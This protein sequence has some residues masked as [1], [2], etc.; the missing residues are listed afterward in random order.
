MHL[1]ICKRPKELLPAVKF[2]E[3]AHYLSTDPLMGLRVELHSELRF[4]TD[5]AGFLLAGSAQWA[6]DPS[7][8]HSTRSLQ[9]SA[10][11]RI[12]IYPSDQGLSAA[13]LV[14]IGSL[15]WHQYRY[16]RTIAE[17]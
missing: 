8:L 11:L 15:Y 2:P 13:D 6:V 7:V 17:W 3:Q 12:L 4:V 5:P 1:V 16:L 10:S 14:N 9:S